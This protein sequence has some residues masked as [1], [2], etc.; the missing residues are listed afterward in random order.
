MIEILQLPFMQR[1]L[2]AGALAGFLLP[3]V[4]NYIV[5]KKLS[6]LGD[7]SSHIA[8]AAIGVTTLFG[9]VT[10]L[11]VYLTPA[12]AIYAI[13]IIINRLKIPGDQ[14]LAILLAVG[15][16]VA[17]LTISFGAR[18]NLNAVLFG[19]LLF[20]TDEDIITA[21]AVASATGLFISVNFGKTILYT[22]NEELA[23]V[24][25]V[26]IGYY[27]F[28]FAVVAGLSIVAGIKVA[29]VLLVTALVAVPTAASSLISSSFKKG[30]IASIIFG[31]SST[32]SGIIASYYLGITPGAA[33]VI[34]LV[35]ILVVSV[36]LWRLKIRI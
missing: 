31:I 36:I 10:D 34:I 22:V 1:A 18:V 24:K 8:F 12:V 33:S 21:A 7:A 9:F 13:L 5:P 2:A 15:A 30:I 27:Q 26:R 19:S 25:G 6:L 14:A 29:G 17:S 3:L 23:R 11:I 32:T 20:V 28:F 4:G 16:S 35:S